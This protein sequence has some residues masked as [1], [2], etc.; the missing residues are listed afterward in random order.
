MLLITPRKPN[1][2]IRKVARVTLN[3]KAKHGKFKRISAYIPGKGHSLQRF[4]NVLVR[5]GRVKDVPGM[6]YT[7]IR[8]VYDL[9]PVE[10]RRQARSKYGAKLTRWRAD[11]RYLKKKYW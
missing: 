11:H 8:G 2:A 6:K 7:L 9:K 1:S 4:S 3:R 5:G 10:T